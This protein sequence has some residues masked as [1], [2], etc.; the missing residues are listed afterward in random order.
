MLLKKY[1]ALSVRDVFD[2]G[3]DEDGPEVSPVMH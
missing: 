3:V 1:T 2:D